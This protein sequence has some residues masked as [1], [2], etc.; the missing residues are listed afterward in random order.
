MYSNF[1][2][3]YKVNI[4]SSVKL[5]KSLLYISINFNE[6]DKLLIKAVRVRRRITAVRL[7]LTTYGLKPQNTMKPFALAVVLFTKPAKKDLPGKQNIINR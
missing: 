3:T 7:R 5:R 1:F 4:A 6:G 2:L